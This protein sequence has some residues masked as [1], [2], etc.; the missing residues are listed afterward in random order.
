MIRKKSGFLTFC[1][2]FI[3]GAGQMYMGYMKRGVSL[4]T[5]FSLSIL[6]ASW[7]SLGPLLFALPIIW[8]F[9]FFDTFNL[10]GMP[11]DEFY[12]MEDDYLILPGFT[13]GKSNQLLSKYRMVTAIILIFIGFTILWN[14]VYGLFKKILPEAISDIIF[15]FGHYF[16]QLL[17]GF[18][19]IAL[20]VYLVIGKK[21]NLDAVEKSHT[22][23]DKGGMFND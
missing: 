11:D 15:R 13:K 10:H 3:P 20:G 14:N 16:P 2:A 6:F 1:F 23:E 22:L 18:V 19:I 8:F 12:A 5:A 17:I 21:K 9:S 7:L 4:M